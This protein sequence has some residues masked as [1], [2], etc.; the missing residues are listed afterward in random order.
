MKFRLELEIDQPRDRVVALFLDPANLKA[1]QPDLLSHVQIGSGDPA[2][3][4]ARS[5]QIHRYG[6]QQVEMIQ[7]ITRNEH[8]EAFGATFEADGIWNLIENR[9]ADLDGTRTRWEIDAEFRCSGIIVKLM[10]I[11]APGM[12]RRQTMTFMQRFKAFA[13]TGKGT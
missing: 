10:T 9:F 1:W 8:P 11:F 13:E 2:A 4:G 6:R 5:K 3:V 12:F 7:T